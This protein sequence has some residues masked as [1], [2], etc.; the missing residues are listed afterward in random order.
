MPDKT[1]TSQSATLS[2]SGNSPSWPLSS[3]GGDVMDRGKI[4]KAVRMILE[5]I[6]EDPDREGLQETPRRVADM[7]EEIFSGLRQ[8]PAEVLAIRFHVEH[9]ELVL[10]KDIPFFSA[11]EH[12]LLPFYGAAHIAYLPGKQT[13]TGLSKLA[14][15]VDGVAKRPQIQERMTNTIANLLQRELEPEGVLVVIEAEHLCMNMR[16]IKKPG[17]KTVTMASRGVF[18]DP[19]RSRDV[20]RM[21]KD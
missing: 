4:I 11:C 20:L 2:R 8:D 10:V 5:A 9:D 19:G 18:S 17:S 21:I 1:E 12:H 14:R 6:G 16:G 13:V 15:L 7:Y 3:D